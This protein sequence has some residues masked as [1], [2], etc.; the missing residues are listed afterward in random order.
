MSTYTIVPKRQKAPV[1]FEREMGEIPEDFING[2]GSMM[3]FDASPLTYTGETETFSVPEGMKIG[4]GDYTSLKVGDVVMISFD[5]EG[6]KSEIIV[7]SA[8]KRPESAK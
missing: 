6:G 8:M 7:P 1:L 3:G 4:D 2:I 5:R